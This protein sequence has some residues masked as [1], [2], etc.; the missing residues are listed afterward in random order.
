MPG[1]VLAAIIIPIVVASGLAIWIAAVFRPGR[2][3]RDPGEPPRPG[4]VPE[5]GDRRAAR[6]SQPMQEVRR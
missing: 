4:D 2:P 3:A 5:T 6:T 1:P